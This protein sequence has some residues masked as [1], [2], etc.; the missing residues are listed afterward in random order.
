MACC[1]NSQDVSAVM[2]FARDNHLPLSVRGG[3][4]NVAGIAFCEGGSMIGLSQMKEIRVNLERG[5]ATAQPG[6]IFLEFESPFN[7]ISR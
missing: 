1:K 2:D 3:G 5:M 6:V 7:S 4:H